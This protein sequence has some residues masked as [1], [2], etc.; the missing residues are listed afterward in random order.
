[1]M[2]DSVPQLHLFTTSD[3]WSF[4][5]RCVQVT[6]LFTWCKH[7]PG[8]S[9][10]SRWCLENTTLCVFR[11]R[12]VSLSRGK[13][14]LFT[15]FLFYFARELLISF[16]GWHSWKP[17]NSIKKKSLT[18][19]LVRSPKLVLFSACLMFSVTSFDTQVWHQWV[20]RDSF[21][22]KR[23][24]WWSYRNQVMVSDSCYICVMCHPSVLFT[25]EVTNQQA[26]R[27]VGV[28]V[29]CSLL[30]VAAFPCFS[31]NKKR[32]F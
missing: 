14:F 7:V 4:L 6:L 11:N 3:L 32:D 1:M 17:R 24:K 28:R 12:K 5:W 19:S 10:F 31:Q 18:L 22:V 9:S 25:C 20:C 15:W 26:R 30:T 8:M 21:L 29:P 27:S 23:I 13:S 16:L 2:N